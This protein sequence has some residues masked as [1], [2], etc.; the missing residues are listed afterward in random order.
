MTFIKW[1]LEGLFG[2]LFRNRRTMVT[3]GFP[4]ILGQGLDEPRIEPKM[5]FFWHPP[6]SAAG[7]SAAAR[8]GGARGRIS[9]WVS[10]LVRRNRV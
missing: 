4:V 3:A 6:L 8:I 9:G 7:D 5:I 10:R 1:R 2:R